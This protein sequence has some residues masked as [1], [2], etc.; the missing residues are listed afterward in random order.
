MCPPEFG[1]VIVSNVNGTTKQCVEKCPDGTM[2]YRNTSECVQS[3]KDGNK[4]VLYSLSHP[5]KSC[6]EI[7]TPYCEYYY[8]TG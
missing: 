8:K 6:E 4:S 7:N 5:Y 3:C 2:L 1:V